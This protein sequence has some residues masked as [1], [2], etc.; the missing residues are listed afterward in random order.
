M[1]KHRI[2]ASVERGFAYVVIALVGLCMVLL[3]IKAH[4]YAELDSIRVFYEGR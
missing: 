4:D 2:P 1:R 3:I